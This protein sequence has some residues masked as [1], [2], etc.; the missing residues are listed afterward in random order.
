M[1]KKDL[2]YLGWDKKETKELQTGPDKFIK[3]GRFTIYFYCFLFYIFTK[4]SLLNIEAK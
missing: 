1:L 2:L 3:M 4:L